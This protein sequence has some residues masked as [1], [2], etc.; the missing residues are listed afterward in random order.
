MENKKIN[1]NLSSNTKELFQLRTHNNTLLTKIKKLKHCQK[2]ELSN[3][4]LDGR[5]LENEEENQRLRNLNQEL[6]KQIKN[7]KEDK[8]SQDKKFKIQSKN[9]LLEKNIVQI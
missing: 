9:N 2:T 1:E 7:L 6:E 5:I 3:E 4:D 8:K